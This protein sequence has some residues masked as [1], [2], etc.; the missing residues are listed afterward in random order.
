MNQEK[1]YPIQNLCD[2][3][4]VAR[5]AYYK[6][7]KRTIPKKEKMDK[8]LQELVKLI[9]HDPEVDRTYGYRRINLV[10]KSWGYLYD[11]KTILRITRFLGIQSVI[12]KK[13]KVYPTINPDHVTENHLNRDFVSETPNQKWCTDITEMKDSS[14]NKLYL[15]A[16]IDLYDLSIVSY[17]YS[18]RNNNQLV[19]ETLRAAFESN[20]QAKPMIHSDRGSQ[21][22]SYMYHGLMEE[23]GFVQSMSRAGYCL[24]NQPIERFFGLIK[25]EYYYRNTFS[26]IPTLEKG[27]NRFIDF[28]NKR[29]VTLKFNGLSPLMVREQYEIVS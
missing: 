3:L 7:I 16:I 29:R 12:R 1:G 17:K 25:S 14:G 22:T 9:Y 20:P 26:I 27:L 28:Y 5:S 24:D 2:I 23:Y 6:W 13:K 15:S 19:E 10:L 8:F 18:N 4:G 11:D 21:Y